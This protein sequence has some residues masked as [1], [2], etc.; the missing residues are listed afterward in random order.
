MTSL[1]QSRA[2][3]SSFSTGHDNAHIYTYKIKFKKDSSDY[4]R[5]EGCWHGNGRQHLKRKFDPDTKLRKVH[6]VSPSWLRD[7]QN[8][9]KGHLRISTLY[10]VTSS[11]KLAFIAPRLSGFTQCYAVI[12]YYFHFLALTIPIQRISEKR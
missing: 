8:V 7:L 5:G 1:C 9:Y 3:I 2:R 10:K 4:C 11:K 6:R 12:K